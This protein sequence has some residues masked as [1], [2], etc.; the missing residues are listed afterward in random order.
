[1]SGITKTNSKEIQNTSSKEKR[2]RMP[3]KEDKQVTCEELMIR[4]ADFPGATLGA[5]RQWIFF[6]FSF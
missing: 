1:M 2:L 4:I 6:V 5:R 3:R